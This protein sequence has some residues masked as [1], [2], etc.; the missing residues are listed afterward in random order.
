MDQG[1]D[2]ACLPRSTGVA[3]RFLCFFT[4]IHAVQPLGWRPNW[5]L[6]L[7]TRRPGLARDLPHVRGPLGPSAPRSHSVPSRHQSPRVVP[8]DAGQAERRPPEV[9]TGHG[10][11]RPTLRRPRSRVLS[12]LQTWKHHARLPSPFCHLWSR[13]GSPLGF[14]GLIGQ[15]PRAGPAHLM[16]ADAAAKGK[17]LL[18]ASSS[19]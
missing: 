3:F 7:S 18:V 13:P 10:V 2:V 11:P 4:L 17:S 6:T 1:W 15:K 16:A 14:A 12:A 8:H 19:H 5:R 9:F